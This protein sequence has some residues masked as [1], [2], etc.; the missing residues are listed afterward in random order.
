MPHL[1]S[2]SLPLS[3]SRRRRKRRRLEERERRRKAFIIQAF[4]RGNSSR[5]T[6]KLALRLLR[7][8]RKVSLSHFSHHLVRSVGRILTADSSSGGGGGSS[9]A[10]LILDQGAEA[11]GVPEAVHLAG[12]EHMYRNPG[13]RQGTPMFLTMLNQPVVVCSGGEDFSPADCMLLCGL[14]RHPLCRIGR[15]LFQNVDGRHTTYEFD[16]VQTIGKCISLRSVV[17][18][19]GQ[20]SAQFLNG[21]LEAVQKSNPRVTEVIIEDMKYSVFTPA[22]LSSVGISGGKLVGDFFNYSVP[23]LK[24]LSLHGLGLRDEHMSAMISGLG[25]NS[26]VQTLV[27]SANLLEDDS[28]ASILRAISANRRSVLSVL[29]FSWNLVTGLTS[30]LAAALKNYKNTVFGMQLCI[31]LFNN[32]LRY[33]LEASQEYRHDLKIFYDFDEIK[34]IANDEKKPPK[35]SKRGAIIA[36]RSIANTATNP[37]RKA[38]GGSLHAKGVV[39][40]KSKP[41]NIMHSK[42]FSGIQN[43]S[44]F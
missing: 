10:T 21:L 36:E 26:S 25:V 37:T 22:E 38:L 1:V 2:P 44:D 27:L 11:G 19:G 29:D 20:W 34:T 4:F 42:T 43:S 16:L 12:G 18:I 17:V 32:H 9:Y 15:L 31:L 7:R 39:K 8:R 6:T 5:A 14:L 3:F 24:T 41:T 30:G 40:F 35:S 28:L 13:V 33:H 23:G